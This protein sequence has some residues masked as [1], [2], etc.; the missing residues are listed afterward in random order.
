MVW[1]LAH[2][3]TGSDF[4]ALFPDG[5][6]QPRYVRLQASARRSCFKTDERKGAGGDQIWV[7][8]RALGPVADGTAVSVTPISASTFLWWR[9][10]HDRY[11]CLPLVAT[12][13]AFASA[14]ITTSLAIGKSSPVWTVGDGVISASLLAAALLGGLAAAL[15]AAVGVLKAYQD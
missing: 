2:R 9:L 5:A 10:F 4:Q 11:V 13:C 12:L 3:P 7:T 14:G 8:V 15:S 1:S 6:A